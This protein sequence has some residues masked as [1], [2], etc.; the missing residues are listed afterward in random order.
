VV[1]VRGAIGADSIQVSPAKNRPFTGPRWGRVRTLNG[2]VG[3]FA[4]PLVV[5]LVTVAI[6]YFIAGKLGQA[7]ITVRSGNLG[8]VWPAYGIAL[9]SMLAYGCRVWPAVG[10]SAFLIAFSSPVPAGTALGQAAGATAGAI[11]GTLLLRRLPAFAP[12]L[13]RLRD[14]LALIVVGAFGSAV[15]SASIGLASLYA[16]GLQPYSGLLPA[17]LIY[18]LGDAT[19]VLLIT[20]L[21][22]TLPVLFRTQSPRRLMELA[23]LMSLLTAACLF[24][25]GDLPIFPVRTHVLAFAVLPFVMWA[26]IAFGTGGAALSVLIIGTIATWFTAIGSGPFA[27]STAFVNAALLDVLFVVLAVSGLVLAAA[28]TERERAEAERL[29]LV[30]DRAVVESR[31]QLAAIVDSSH[32]AIISTDR[33]GL[34]LS[35]NGA[36]QKTFGF[37]E[38]EV[39]GRPLTVLVPPE[40]HHQA[41]QDLRRIKD[42]WRIRTYETL[43]VTKS[44]ETLKISVTPSGLVDADGCVRGT[45]L[46]VRDITSQKRAEEALSTMNRKLVEVQEQERARIAR[47]LHDDIGQRL[48]LLAMKLSTLSRQSVAGGEFHSDTAA[49]ENQAFE[50]AADVQLLSHRLHPS[51]LGL[52]GITTVMRQCCEEFA[53]QYGM[54]VDF[55]THELPAQLPEETSLALLRVLQEA[56]HNAAKHSGAA[57]CEVRLRAEPGAIHLTVSDDGRGFDVEPARRRRGIGLVSMDERM[58]LVNGELLVDS[59]PQKGTR[60]RASCR[61]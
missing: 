6:A 50:V 46:I 36:A 43:G 59:Q 33:D 39:I 26:A 16:T 4:N 18:W 58:K 12:T 61:L 49:L 5:Q 53:V 24:V 8:P 25:F 14:A 37:T 28:I 30:R 47:E 29:R 35:W 23:V 42:G 27:A 2:G 52:L 32:D 13:P 19:G 3:S 48:A 15:F 31:L 17:W 34:I 51:K 54:E 20:P 45:A 1:N 40:L 7:T 60:I 56:L 22:F 57:R 44:G 10:I 9:A 41:R 21:V 38:A 11:A 55:V